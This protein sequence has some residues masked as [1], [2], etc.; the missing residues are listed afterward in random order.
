MVQVSLR[1]AGGGLVGLLAL[2]LLAGAFLVLFTDVGRHGHDVNVRAEPDPLDVEELRHFSPPR[3][4]AGLG[5][6]QKTE[7]KAVCACVATAYSNGQVEVLR[8]WR[9]ELPR[10]LESLAEDDLRSV[11]RPIIHV[12]EDELHTKLNKIL[13]KESVGEAYETVA[14]FERH[15]EALLEISLIY[16]DILLRRRDFGVPFT[17]LEPSVFY[18][19]KSYRDG[20]H[21]E[22]RPDM[23]ESAEKLLTKWI[24]Q[25][26]SKNGYTRAQLVNRI[27][28]S[29][30]WADRTMKQT[31]KS[32]AELSQ[33]SVSQTVYTLVL[34]G[35]TPKWLDEFKD[36]PRHATPDAKQ[37]VK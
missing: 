9:R 2:A 23:K 36:I 7:L 5:S 20:F 34:F 33:N 10:M 17:L 26:E 21:A 15:A 28:R 11:W 30:V 3:H 27:A 13:M 22:G 1:Q 14:D 6:A 12:M 29:R 32:W 16:G 31:G 35:Y 4:E 37:P 18:R 8:E 19:I 24:N 25:V